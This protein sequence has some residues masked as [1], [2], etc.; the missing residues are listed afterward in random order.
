VTLLGMG[1]TRA[2]AHTKVLNFT[3][4]FAS[5]VVLALGGHVLWLAG[6]AMAVGQIIGGRLG[7]HAAMRF[8]P[9]LIRPLLVVISL[10]IVLKL[11][12]DPGNPLRQA[13]VGWCAA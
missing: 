11:L 5:V 9:K 12:S 6:G 4:N 2:T 13:L 7:S 10:A 8:G 3:S 1:L